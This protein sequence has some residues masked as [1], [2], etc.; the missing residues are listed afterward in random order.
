LP[1]SGLPVE[2]MGFIGTLPPVPPSASWTG[3]LTLK[4]ADGRIVG[5]SCFELEQGQG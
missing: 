1:A 5:V 4:L 2:T 3:Y